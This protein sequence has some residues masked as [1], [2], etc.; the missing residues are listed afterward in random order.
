MTSLR[1][2]HNGVQLLDEPTAVQL[3][4]AIAASRTLTRFTGHYVNFWRDRAA[5]AAVLRA[6]T[7]HPTIRE[8]NLNVN[9]PHDPVAAGAALGALVAANTPALQVL[10]IHG[11]HFGDAGLAPLF[12]ALPRNTHLR[13]IGCSNN[14]MS[15]DFARDHFLPAVRANTSLRTL[16]A[17]L[18]WGDQEDG[19]APLEVL[20]A[21]A[22]VAA[23]A[24]ADEP[25][26]L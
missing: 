24:A 11:S 14:D 7:G 4:D 9:L 13:T 12:D 5:A 21:E 10:H 18:W 2:T 15:A 25:T 26:Q 20:E 16:V 8:V 17:S 1:I 3:A 23:R 6:L 22:L 19:V